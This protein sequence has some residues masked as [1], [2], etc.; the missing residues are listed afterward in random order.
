MNYKTPALV[1]ALHTYEAAVKA[2]RVGDGTPEQ[3]AAARQA[4][5]ELGAT[6]NALHCAAG[7]FIPERIT[8]ADYPQPVGTIMRGSFGSLAVV[9]ER[10]GFVFLACCAEHEAQGNASG[11][12][13]QASHGRICDRS[14]PA[15]IADYDCPH[16]PGQLFS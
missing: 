14:E 9:V 15:G 4:A 6:W 8:M 1:A 5:T 11:Y 13:V 10:D 2:E 3:T 16:V 12:F 7:G